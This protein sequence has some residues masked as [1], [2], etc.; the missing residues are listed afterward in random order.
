MTVV[1]LAKQLAQLNKISVHSIKIASKKF[2]DFQAV[3]RITKMHN[4]RNM[5]IKGETFPIPM[6]N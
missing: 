1:C 4:I 6:I 5:K 2:I 3:D